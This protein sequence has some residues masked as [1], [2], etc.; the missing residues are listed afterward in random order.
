M[1]SLSYNARI[2]C[3][4]ISRVSRT[5]ILEFINQAVQLSDVPDVEKDKVLVDSRG[6]G[7]FQR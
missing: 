3:E 1:Y 2:I 6:Q 5:Q 7:S 4:T